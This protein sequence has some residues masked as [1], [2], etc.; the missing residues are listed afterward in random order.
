[1]AWEYSIGGGDMD[2]AERNLN[3]L[4]DAIWSLTGII[5]QILMT[6]EWWDSEIIRNRLG[7]QWG[8]MQNYGKLRR[9]NAKFTKGSYFTAGEFD[10]WTHKFVKD[11]IDGRIEGGRTLETAEGQEWRQ[12]PLIEVLEN[13]TDEWAKGG[14]ITGNPYTISTITEKKG[15]G[16]T[17]MFQKNA[18]FRID[19]KRQNKDYDMPF[20]LLSNFDQEGNR[21][22][23]WQYEQLIH[24]TYP[25]I[26]EDGNYDNF[27][28]YIFYGETDTGGYLWT[29]KVE[30]EIMP[31]MNENLKGSKFPVKCFLM[32]QF[33]D[34]DFYRPWFYNESCGSF[35]FGL[36]RVI[37]GVS[38][39]G[40]PT[41]GMDNTAGERR[42]L[43]L[44]YENVIYAEHGGDKSNEAEHIWRTAFLGEP[45]QS[46]GTPWL[47]QWLEAY[48]RPEN[49][50]FGLFNWWW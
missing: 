31:N 14:K 13:C 36:E 4:K 41:G 47:N 3:S 6:T 8:E 46:H 43:S 23:G 48:P 27:N 49:S 10:R 12:L 40:E 1:M 50:M 45:F 7:H 22:T 15:Y 32:F 26:M 39:F 28:P 18:V 16:S 17:R 30:F 25:Q 37:A 24:E 11:I 19:S 34:S 29:V 38:R 21:P 33:S 35:N 44:A 20:R 42:A 5:P 2:I 9:G